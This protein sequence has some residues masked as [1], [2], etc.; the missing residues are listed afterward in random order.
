M[1]AD[2]SSWESLSENFR[3]ALMTALTV[4]EGACAFLS[5]KG[6]CGWKAAAVG[7]AAAERTPTYLSWVRWGSGASV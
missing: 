6:A 5:K 2:E 4:G 7:G 3:M 1:V